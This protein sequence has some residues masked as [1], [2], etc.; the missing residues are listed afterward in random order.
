MINEAQHL[1]QCREQI[2]KCQSWLERVPIDFQAL[3]EALD[4]AVDKVEKR[5]EKAAAA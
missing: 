1:K 3:L 2:R 5:I 4:G